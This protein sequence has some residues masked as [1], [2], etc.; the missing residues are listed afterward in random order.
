MKKI[1][2]LCLMTLLIVSC[3]NR[4]VQRTNNDSIITEFQEKKILDNENNIVTESLFE[5]DS[6][7]I[8]PLARVQCH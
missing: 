1:I 7:I 3:N 6:N 4:S 5:K 2:S 8:F